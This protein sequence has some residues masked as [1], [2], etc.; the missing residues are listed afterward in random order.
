MYFQQ[1]YNKRFVLLYVTLQLSLSG[2]MLQILST[3]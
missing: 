3:Y 2:T 1:L